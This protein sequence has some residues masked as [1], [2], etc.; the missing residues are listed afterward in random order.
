[1]QGRGGDAR[2]PRNVTI[3]WQA[4]FAGTDAAILLQQKQVEL[5]SLSSDEQ[6]FEASA[7]AVEMA[8][9]SD[10][11]QDMPVFEVTT[12]RLRKAIKKVKPGRGSPDGCTGEMFAALPG[13]QVDLLA[14][15]FSC[16]LTS[17]RIPEA[18]TTCTRLL[19]PKVVGASSL[20]KFRGIA[21]LS[22]ARKILG[23]LWMQM[24]PDLVYKS[25]Q[26]G[27][28][29][30]MQAADGVFV[31][32]RAAELS[33][34][35][36][37]PISICQLDLSRAFDRVKHSAIIKALKL[38]G[39]TLHCLAALCA[40]LDQS[41]TATVLGHVQAAASTMNRGLPQ[42]APESPLIFTLVTE[43]VL[44]PLLEK[45]R[46]RGGGWSLDSFWLACVCFADD[47][48]LVSRSKSDLQKMIAEVREAFAVV[49]LEV[50][51][52][53]CHWTSRHKEAGG[54]LDIGGELV[55]WENS[56]VF[57][58]CKLDLSGNDEGAMRHRQA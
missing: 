44:R 33:R 11:K 57:A 15:F 1:M 3:N 37:R 24:L 19:L 29:S 32:K 39:C 48:L 54:T 34:E 55:G 23:Y 38:Q 13:A 5:Y 46:D 10:M 27:F 43:Y 58:G 56:V 41:Q 36:G 18:W 17:L 8:K 4:L 51:P 12:E 9:W 47:I 45:W 50:S 2:K 21:C 6:V 25:F 35:W 49:G 16:T 7:K 22:T 52:G 53:K 28:V 31:V 26:T 30:G 40:M 14:S 42:G 20:D